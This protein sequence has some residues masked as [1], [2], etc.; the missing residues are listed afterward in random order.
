MRKHVI[1]VLVL[2]AIAG[3]YF[4]IQHWMDRENAIDRAYLAQFGTKGPVV[5]RDQIARDMDIV[6]SDSHR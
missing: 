6:Q 3:G 2:G 4:G 1:V 5:S